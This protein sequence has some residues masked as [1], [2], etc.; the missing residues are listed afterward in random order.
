MIQ[1]W[2]V[3]GVRCHIHHYAW[4]QVETHHNQMRRTCDY[5][6]VPPLQRVYSHNGEEN[7]KVVSYNESG[8]RIVNTVLITITTR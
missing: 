4:I 2:G 6:F 5:G 1:C 7:A 3:E 8:R